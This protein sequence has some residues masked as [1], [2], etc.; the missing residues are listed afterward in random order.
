LESRREKNLLL[1]QTAKII[2]QEAQVWSISELNGH[3]KVFWKNQPLK[4]NEVPLLT[5]EEFLKREIYSVEWNSAQPLI[6]LASSNG[7]FST[8]DG[9]N[10]WTQ[11][12]QF[13]NENHPVSISP[14]GSWFVGSLKSNDQGQT[15]RHFIRMDLLARLVENQSKKT[16]KIFRLSEIKFKNSLMQIKIDTGIQQFRLATKSKS[17]TILDWDF[18]N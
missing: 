1:R 2:K 5:K 14:D 16:P 7:I 18:V 12:L 17:D 4:T 10:N 9:G 11:L 13:K 6:G 8:I 15:F 3:G